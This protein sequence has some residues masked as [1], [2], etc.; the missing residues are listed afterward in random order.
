M[1]HLLFADQC[2]FHA[3]RLTDFPLT[4]T[5]SERLCAAETTQHQS[6]APTGI[7][8]STWRCLKAVMTG[9]CG[10]QRSVQKKNLQ[11]WHTQTRT[12]TFLLLRCLFSVA[13]SLRAKKLSWIT[14]S[15]TP[16][17]CSG[18]SSA[19]SPSRHTKSR[20]S[21]CSARSRAGSRRSRC[22]HVTL[23]NSHPFSPLPLS[24]G[25]PGQPL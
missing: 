23:S 14:L 7:S 11:E 24:A 1:T 21:S 16:S 17:R 25:H 19:P 3:Q 9:S 10:T 12:D 22:W 2:R 6:R 4:T 8:G 5:Q 20:S 13:R 18:C 15:S